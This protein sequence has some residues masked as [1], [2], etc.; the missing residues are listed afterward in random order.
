MIS[1]VKM[2]GALGR[3]LRL[4]LCGAFEKVLC[5]CLGPRHNPQRVF[6][7]SGQVS[8]GVIGHPLGGLMTC[9]LF[10]GDTDWTKAWLMS[11]DLGRH[12]M[13]AA[14]VMRIL[15]LRDESAGAKQSEESQ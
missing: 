7:G 9:F 14:M 10:S 12:L 15:I 3:G 1:P 2:Q 6:C 5:Q 11:P 8:F 4:N 13:L